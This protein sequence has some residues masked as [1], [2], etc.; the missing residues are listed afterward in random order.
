VSIGLAA[1]VIAETVIAD[2]PSPTEF[3]IALA[4]YLK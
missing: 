3:E 4:R 1:L 2:V